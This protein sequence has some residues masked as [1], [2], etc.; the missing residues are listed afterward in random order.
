MGKVDMSLTK[1]IDTDH[2]VLPIWSDVIPGNCME[3][4]ST[5]MEGKKRHMGKLSTIL[6]TLRWLKSLVNTQYVDSK[7]II[8]S[9]VMNLVAREDKDYMRHLRMF[10]T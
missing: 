8:D 3:L 2:Q 9:Y 5:V 6:L 7:R 4:K 1:Q 10:H